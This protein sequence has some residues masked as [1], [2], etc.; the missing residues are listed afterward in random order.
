MAGTGSPCICT[1]KT[2]T[3]DSPFIRR[4]AVAVPAAVRN[5]T[6]RTPVAALERYGAA[7]N[8]RHDIALVPERLLPLMIAA[9]L[10]R[11]PEARRSTLL[12]SPLQPVGG[13]DD[14]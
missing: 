6:R 9:F 8:I 2:I 5:R 12:H 7:D 11:V 1:T 14:R 10:G 3:V 13:G 4:P